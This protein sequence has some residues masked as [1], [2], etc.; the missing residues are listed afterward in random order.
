MGFK[1]WEVLEDAYQITKDLWIKIYKITKLLH[2]NIKTIN[3]FHKA[4]ES[5]SHVQIFS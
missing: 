2:I 5:K 1:I 4:R 3:I